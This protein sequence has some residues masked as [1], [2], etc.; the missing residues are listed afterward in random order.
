MKPVSFSKLLIAR[1]FNYAIWLLGLT[2]VVDQSSLSLPQWM[3][4]ALA[5][6][7]MMLFGTLSAYY[8][9]TTLGFKLLRIDI[10]PPVSWKEAFI[11]ALPWTRPTKLVE[12]RQTPLWRYMTACAVAVTSL[13]L[14]F[15]DPVYGFSSGSSMVNSS[16]VQYTHDQKGF[17][18]YF[19]D[20][21]QEAKKPLTPSGET[22]L[23]ITEMSSKE[24]KRIYSLS[25]IKLPKKW[26]LAGDN[27][28]LKV[29]LDLIVKHT[30][31]A[32]LVSKQMTNYKGLK[33]ID[34]T[35]IVDGKEVS[36]RLLM[37]GNTLYRLN[38]EYPKG[39]KVA[40]EEFLSSFSVS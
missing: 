14:Q 38:I 16:W 8:F 10:E 7:M 32:V 40:K 3:L 2:V 5:P 36:G 35:M 9:K 29:G 20:E 1:V 27:T 39:A 17:T 25:F 26:G 11:A 23:N 37:H 19:P 31:N 28:I 4:W 15:N 34:Y 24:K 12:N 6:F 18:V 13:A 21:P 33:A 22:G 30:P